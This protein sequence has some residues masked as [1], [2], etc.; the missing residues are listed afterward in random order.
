MTGRP[1][2]VDFR[3]DRGIVP[4]RV[5]KMC[6]KS[7][8]NRVT[9]GHQVTAEARLGFSSSSVLRRFSDAVAVEDLP[10]SRST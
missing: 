2:N 6:R 1:G 7:L 5:T 8:P 10:G 9:A 3:S 4:L